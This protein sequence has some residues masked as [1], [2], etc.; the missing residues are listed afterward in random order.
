MQVS[1]GSSCSWTPE[2]QLRFLIRMIGCVPNTGLRSK[3]SRS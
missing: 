1:G 3:N 2:L